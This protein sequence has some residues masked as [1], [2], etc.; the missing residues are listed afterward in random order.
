LPNQQAQLFQASILLNTKEQRAK[1]MAF[2]IVAVVLYHLAMPSCWNLLN[3]YS[4]FMK[5]MWQ[6]MTSSTEQLRNRSALHEWWE[7]CHL[8]AWCLEFTS[9]S[10]QL[11]I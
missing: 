6:R 8:R 9:S 2:Q 10:R 5:K 3:Y 4:R 11:W 1:P 7:Y